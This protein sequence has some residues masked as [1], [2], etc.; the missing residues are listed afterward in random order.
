MNSIEWKK[1]H[2]FMLFS[3]WC[4]Q[5]TI[6]IILS[7]CGIRKSIFEISLFVYKWWWGTPPQ[8]FVA[9]LS[10][11]FKT[12]NYKTGATIADISRHLKQGHIVVINWW[13]ETEGHYSI[14]SECKK[15]ILTLID[16]SRERE[17]QWSMATKELKERWYDTLNIQ[18]S[19]YHTG[20]MIWVDPKTKK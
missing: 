7:A 16:S 4:G 20:Y 18:N 2:R 19:L 14:V 10:R 13:D 3:G 9:Y 12:V 6:Q 8:L 17:W 15:G 5:T 11:Y 1:H